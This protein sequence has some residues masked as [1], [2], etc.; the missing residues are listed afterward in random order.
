VIAPS[1]FLA[2][3]WELVGKP[4]SKEVDHRSAISRAYYSLFHDA[5]DFLAAKY[6]SKLVEAIK[7]SL[8]SNN[9][10]YDWQRVQSLDRRYFNEKNVNLHRIIADTLLNLRSSAAKAAANDFKSFR[11]KRNEADY[12]ISNNYDMTKTVTELS[13]LQRIITAIRKL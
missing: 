1:D 9:V 6:R 11:K 7:N 10:T 2:Q 12:D 4:N 5:F 13:E 8:L 3:A